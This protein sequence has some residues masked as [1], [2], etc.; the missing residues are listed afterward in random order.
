MRAGH[1]G[2]EYGR[3]WPPA[4]L[5]SAVSRF[6]AALA[7]ILILDF[8]LGILIRLW[9]RRAV[10]SVLA[11]ILIPPLAAVLPFEPDVLLHSSGGDRGMGHYYA[12]LGFAF[13]ALFELFVSFVCFC[14]NPSACPPKKPTEENEGNEES[15]DRCFGV[16]EEFCRV[17]P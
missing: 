1:L 16:P 5:S 6:M 12:V 9:T 10:W 8:I 7:T 11:C 2:R 4:S 17:A 3:A 14:W 13:L 15:K